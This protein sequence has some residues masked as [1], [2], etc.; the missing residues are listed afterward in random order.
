VKTGPAVHIACPK[1][2]ATATRA[3]FFPGEDRKT[4]AQPLDEAKRILAGL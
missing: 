4:L 2:M 3:R 1:P